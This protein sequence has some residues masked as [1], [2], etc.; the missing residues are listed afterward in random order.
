[1]FPIIFLI[2]TTFIIGFTFYKT[3]MDS[4]VCLAVILM[5]LPIYILFIKMDK[6]KKV[7]EKLDAF[8][9]FIQKLTYSALEETKSQ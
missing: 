9:L 2:L 5:G 1:V 3:P 7:Q 6:P 8:T 4:F